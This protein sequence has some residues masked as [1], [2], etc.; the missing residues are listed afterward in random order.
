MKDSSKGTLAIIA[1][2]F[3]WGCTPTVN[4]IGLGSIPPLL[5]LGISYLIGGIIIAFVFRKKLKFINRSIVYFSLITSIFLSLGSIL[6]ILGLQY[7]TPIKSG[8]LISFETI[9]IPIFCFFLTRKA[10]EPNEVISLLCAFIGLILINHNGIS[11]EFNIGTLLTILAAAAFS[12][13][14]ILIGNL[15]KKHVPI[16]ISIIELIATSIICLSFSAITERSSAAFS[17]ASTL[18]VILS[19]VFCSGVAFSLQ[20]YGQKYISPLRT[21]IIFSTTPI[22]SILVSYLVFNNVL[23]LLAVIGS[24]LIIFSIVNVNINTSKIFSFRFKKR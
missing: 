11:F 15:V 10:M 19:G 16:L 3:F 23:S 1:T 6:E 2:C 22:F 9:F 20:N 12:I 18:A 17:S 7:I 14:T 21:G 4:K 13:Q 24:I 5:F 8:L